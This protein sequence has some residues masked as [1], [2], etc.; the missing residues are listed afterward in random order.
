MEE[1]KRGSVYFLQEIPSGMIKIGW[2]TDIEFRIK[3]LQTG[4]S[5]ELKLLLLLENRPL[6]YEKEMHKIVK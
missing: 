3:T 2:A 4:N 6:R 5:G 1:D